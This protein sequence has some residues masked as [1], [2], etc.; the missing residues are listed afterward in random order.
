MK[1][2]ADARGATVQRL[3]NDAKAKAEAAMAAITDAVSD[4]I[5]TPSEK[6]QFKI[7]WIEEY[8][9]FE[10][11]KLKAQEAG[12]NTS[13]GNYTGY[14]SAFN[15]IND[16]FTPVW[17]SANNSQVDPTEWKTRFENL[18]KYKA[19]LENEISSVIKNIAST[20]LANTQQ[21]TDSLKTKADS[22]AL[23]T[24][25]HDVTT[26]EGGVFNVYFHGSPH[27]IALAIRSVPEFCLLCYHLYA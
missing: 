1:A 14:V 23:M 11:L 12:I 4:S 15:Y 6:Q 27:E 2:Y 8:Q 25:D 7:K 10:K 17:N 24:L 21:L 18:R 16:T 22:S 9:D 19:L 3:S 20:A 13:T 26:I 5:L